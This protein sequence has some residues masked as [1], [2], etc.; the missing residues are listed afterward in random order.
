MG[1]RW[2]WKKNGTERERKEKKGTEKVKAFIF[3]IGS[4][5]IDATS[6]SNTQAILS[7]RF[8]SER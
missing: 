1:D 8:Y 3:Q 2:E 4:K 5:E 6:S 7:A